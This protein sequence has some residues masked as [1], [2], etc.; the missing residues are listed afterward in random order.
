M[1]AKTRIAGIV[2]EDGKIL[3]LVPAGNYKELWTPGGK[4]EEGESD[5]ECLTREFQEELGVELAEAKFFKE[6]SC[7]NFYNNTYDLIERVYVAKIKGELK[8]AMEIKGVVWFSKEDF[9]N[10]KFPMITHTQEE[11]IPDLI[12][13]RIW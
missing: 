10:K 9:E 13:A 3:M 2:I 1:P 8:P 4:I 5:L 11:L 12:E 7:A 6:Y